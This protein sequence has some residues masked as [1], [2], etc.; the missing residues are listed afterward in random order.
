MK[1]SSSNA[2]HIAA[3]CLLC[4]KDFGIKIT[5]PTLLI[6]E[7]PSSEVDM[8]SDSEMLTDVNNT[9]SLDLNVHR[10]E[11]LRLV[12]DLHVVMFAKQSE[13]G[14]LSLKQKFPKIFENFCLYSDVCLQ[15]ERNDY[16]A[17]ARRFLHELFMETN[18]DQFYQHADA[19]MKKYE[20]LKPIELSSSSLLSSSSSTTTT[21]TTT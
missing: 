16:K 14:L 8:K 11:V 21:T 17:T 13:Q 9:N 6:N 3:K 18:V 4:C 10:D 2:N 20:H 7:P 12:S 1:T 19:I 5:Y 15:M